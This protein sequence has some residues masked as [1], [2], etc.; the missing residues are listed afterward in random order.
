MKKLNA[1]FTFILIIFVGAGCTADTVLDVNEAPA[2]QSQNGDVE[3]AGELAQAG[4]F[5]EQNA[6]KA[7]SGVSDVYTFADMSRVGTSKLVRTKD[8]I[9]FVLGTTELVHGTVVTLWMVIF[10]KPENCSGGCGADDL[11]NPDVVTDVVYASG[12]VIGSSGKANYAGHRQAGDNSGSIFPAWLGLP[13]PGLLDAQAAEIHSVVRSHG[14]KIPELTGEML[15]S[16]NAGCGPISDPSFPP[17]PEE[18]GTYGPNTCE[19]IQFA[20]HLP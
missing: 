17:I 20:V 12:R 11:G 15:H 3:A 18:L 9:S 10:N 8:G 7:S 14:P 6:G 19:D 4:I 1:I 16:F 5:A 13:S 2:V